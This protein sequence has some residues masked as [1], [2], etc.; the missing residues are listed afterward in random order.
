[1]SS[2]LNSIYMGTGS[3]LLAGSSIGLFTGATVGITLGVVQFIAIEGLQNATRSFSKLEGKEHKFSMEKSVFGS[4][5]AFAMKGALIGA[6][7]G[8]LAS[9]L[10][11]AAHYAWKNDFN[12]EVLTNFASNFIN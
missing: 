12:V 8:F 3:S 5:A 10:A 1:M 6:K 11:S 4:G 2:A 9:P 7:I